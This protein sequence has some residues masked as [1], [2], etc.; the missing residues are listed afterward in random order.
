VKKEFKVI[1]NKRSG[2]VKFAEDL[3][4]LVIFKKINRK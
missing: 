2:N 3:N 4:Y 1:K